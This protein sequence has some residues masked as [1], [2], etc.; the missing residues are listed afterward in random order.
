[1]DGIFRGSKEKTAARSDDRARISTLLS[2]EKTAKPTHLKPLTDNDIRQPPE[3]GLLRSGRRCARQ[4]LPSGLTRGMPAPRR[5]ARLARPQNP[6]AQA[7]P[8]KDEP[9]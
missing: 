9:L 4:S 8:A 5:L 7:I 3:L 2:A 1:M 6:G